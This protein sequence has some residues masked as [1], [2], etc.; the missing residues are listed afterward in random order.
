MPAS[1]LLAGEAS[2]NG[3]P[4]AWLERNGVWPRGALI[5][6]TGTIEAASRGGVRRLRWSIHGA[7]STYATARRCQGTTSF[8]GITGIMVRNYA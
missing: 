7:Q 6:M 3:D 1:F 8:F 5:S 2:K 4:D